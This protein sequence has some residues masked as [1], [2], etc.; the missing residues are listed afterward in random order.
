M[1]V[2]MELNVPL[3]VRWENE[4]SVIGAAILV[5]E[6]KPNLVFQNPNSEG[7][8]DVCFPTVLTGAPKC[9]IRTI[10][11]FNTSL[12]HNLYKNANHDDSERQQYR[13]PVSCI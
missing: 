11:Q 3:R 9:P 7:R 1:I 10:S 6:K 4:R 12:F 5:V 13:L 2:E 8:G